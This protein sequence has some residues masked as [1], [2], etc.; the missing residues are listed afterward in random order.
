MDLFFRE[1]PDHVDNYEDFIKQLSV[2]TVEQMQE[3]NAKTPAEY[4]VMDHLHTY[5]TTAGI[6]YL[7]ITK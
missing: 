1:S 3:L 6:G 5:I 7:R 2:I 4:M